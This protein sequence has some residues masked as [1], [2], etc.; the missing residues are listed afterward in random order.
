MIRVILAE[1]AE[2]LNPA[3]TPLDQA[4]REACY[5][6]ASKLWN[7]GRPYPFKH[8]TARDVRFA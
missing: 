7:D 4:A 5:H 8:R 3:S 2:L 6:F 1:I